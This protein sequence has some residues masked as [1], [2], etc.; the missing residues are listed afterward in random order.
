MATGRRRVSSWVLLALVAALVV[1]WFALNLI[2]GRA[3]G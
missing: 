1:G 2:A 3:G